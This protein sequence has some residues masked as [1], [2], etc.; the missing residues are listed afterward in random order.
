[1]TND[2]WATGDAIVGDVGS[3]HYDDSNTTGEAWFALA[4]TPNRLYAF[5]CDAAAYYF[6][7]YSGTGPEWSGLTFVTSGYAV[8]MS[9]LAEAGVNYSVVI[10]PSTG[11]SN[12][13]AW[14]SVACT[15]GWSEWIQAPDYVTAPHSLHEPSYGVMES[16]VSDYSYT[17]APIDTAGA[18]AAQ[19]VVAAAGAPPYN[20][21]GG[22]NIQAGKS[23]VTEQNPELL[24]GYHHDCEFNVTKT[25]AN[26]TIPTTTILAARDAYPPTLSALTEGVDF[27]LIPSTSDYVEYEDAPSTL[28][29]WQD[30]VVPFRYQE[31]FNDVVVPQAVQS[32]IT[33]AEPPI[34]DW[35]AGDIPPW[36]LPTSRSTLA[37]ITIE[38]GYLSDYTATGVDYGVVTR[39]TTTDVTIPLS[40]MGVVAAVSLCMEPNNDVSSIDVGGGPGGGDWGVSSILDHTVPMQYAYRMPRFRYWKIT[41][42]PSPLP[43]LT[44][45]L[46]DDRVR[47]WGN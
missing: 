10:Y 35:A 31:Y 4:T 18:F 47:F 36:E 28:V 27:T 29:G 3:A 39:D 25:V 17:D 21:G 20:P 6:E 15:L 11:D 9:F 44:G 7:V 14:T 43:N 46:L 32:R 33:Y 26:L 23:G 5:T 22:T 42:I 12:N 24:G 16:S 8:P 1:M 2:T 13:I 41:P 40:D 37:I 45:Q 30:W 34:P 38:P 19:Q